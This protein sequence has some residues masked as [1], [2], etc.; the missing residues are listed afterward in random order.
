MHANHTLADDDRPVPMRLRIVDLI[1]C[2]AAN[3]P[4]ANGRP[5]SMLTLTYMGELE[6]PLAISYSDSMLLVTKL[7]QSLAD[8]DNAFAEFLLKSTSAG[9]TTNRTSAKPTVTTVRM[10]E[11]LT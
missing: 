2:V 11:W 8:H 5:I 9:R 3:A 4:D 10:P 1:D 7:L 6:Q